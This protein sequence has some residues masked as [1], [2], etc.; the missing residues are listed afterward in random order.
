MKNKKSTEVLKEKFSF[1]HNAAFA[2]FSFKPFAEDS[3]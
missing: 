3:L 1:L 2:L